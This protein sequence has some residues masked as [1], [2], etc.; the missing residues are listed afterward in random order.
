MDLLYWIWLSLVLEADADTK[1]ILAHYGTPQAVYEA[2]QAERAAS[3]CFS[4]ARLARMLSVQLGD[5]MEVM[6]ECDRSGWD[7]VTLESRDYPELLRDIPHA[8][9]LLYVSGNLGVLQERLAVAMVGTRDAS[10]YSMRAAHYLAYGVAKGGAAVISGGALGVDSAAHEGALEAGGVTVAVLGSGLADSYLKSNQPLRDKIVEQGG[11][12]VTEYAPLVTARPTNFPKRN[13]IISGMARATVVVEAAEKSGSL[14]TARYAA[15]Q[16]RDVFAV[17]AS[18]L[19]KAYQGTNKLIEEGALVATS[20]PAI[21][22]RYTNEYFT[23][24]PDSVPSPYETQPAPPVNAPPQR[25]LMFDTA[26]EQRRV[27]TEKRMEALQLEEPY[28]TVYEAMEETL[29]PVSRLLEKTG[30]PVPKLLAALT[31]LEIKGL[32]VKAEGNRF[33]RT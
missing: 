7:I 31:V 16:G 19:D 12:L 29:L 23:L 30:L 33:R 1:K 3:G 28:K 15:K 6:R 14:I 27:A 2:S 4:P 13:R 10:E 18:I 11:A 21:I 24:H 22:N 20:A 26:P 8:P 5:A 32:I 17:P 25:Q 9:L